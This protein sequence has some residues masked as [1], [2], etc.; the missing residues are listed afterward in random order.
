MH[1]YSKLYFYELSPGAMH[2][3]LYSILLFQNVYTYLLV[4]VSSKKCNRTQ[5]VEIK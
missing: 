2:S 5:G 1:S 3:L 4:D